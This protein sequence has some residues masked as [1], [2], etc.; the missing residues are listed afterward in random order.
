MKLHQNSRVYITL[1]SWRGIRAN[2][3]ICNNFRKKCAILINTKKYAKIKFKY[4]PFC[5]IINW[6]QI[7]Y[8][9]GLKQN[10]AQEANLIRLGNVRKYYI[11]HTDQHTVLGRMS[12]IF[13]YGY[14][15]SSLLC[16]ID[17]VSTTSMR[18]FHCINY[19]ILHEQRIRSSS[20]QLS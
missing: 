6:L 10:Q 11:Y 1:M 5:F 16:H 3:I 17:Q 15:I 4:T 7:V 19:S 12:S 8:N 20:K 14:N 2:L 9:N 13:N 18:K